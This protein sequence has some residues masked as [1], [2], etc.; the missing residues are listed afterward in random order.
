MRYSSDILQLA[1]PVGTVLVIV[2]LLGGCELLG[3]GSS[4]E[5]SGSTWQLTSFTENEQPLVVPPQQTYEVSFS[6]ESVGAVAD[7]NECSGSYSTDGSEI[8][9]LISCTE[10]AC[11]SNS[12]SL[13][14]KN[15]LLSAET[16][17][18]EEGQLT[19]SY[20]LSQESGGTL[21]FEPKE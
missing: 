8:S 5:L 11:A 6:D 16:Y 4:S 12:L 18:R 10:Q 3:L 17:Q 1:L 9:I 21:T 2:V 15:A 13:Q 14:F 7:C 20:S 19:I